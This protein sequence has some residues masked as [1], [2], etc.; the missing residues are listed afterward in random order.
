MLCLLQ[1]KIDKPLID[2]NSEISIKYKNY[3]NDKIVKAIRNITDQE[4]LENISKEIGIISDKNSKDNNDDFYL[5][6]NFDTT[7]CQ[8]AIIAKLITH[9]KKRLFNWNKINYSLLVFYN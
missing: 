9:N 5:I 4:T 3:L 1:E 2:K 6:E 8:D 7:S